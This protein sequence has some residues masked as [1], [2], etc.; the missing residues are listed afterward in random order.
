MRRFRLRLAYLAAILLILILSV[1]ASPASAPYVPHDPPFV[2]CVFFW[3]IR[4]L[5][6]WMGLLLLLLWAELHNEEIR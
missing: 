2:I 5:L 6:L 4:A 1:R 3:C